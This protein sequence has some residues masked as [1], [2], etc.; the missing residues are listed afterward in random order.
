VI[1]GMR[2]VLARSPGVR[3]VVEFFESMLEN[4]Y[5]VE[6]FVN[7]IHDLGF[8]MC[9]ILP[10]AQLELLPMGEV[11]RGSSYFLL[12]R[13][14]EEDLR[15]NHFVIL[16]EALRY[17]DSFL[18]G[19]RNRLLNDRQLVCSSELLAGSDE[20]V[21][22]FGPYINLAPGKYAFHFQGD[23][24]GALQLKFTKNFGEVL[25]ET[26]IDSFAQPVL[27]ELERTAE[28]FEIVASR[29]NSLRNLQLSEIGVV[30]T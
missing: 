24:Q 17:L 14:H 16:P 22:F 29:T 3:L 28:K 11:P 13:T 23:L 12:T 1:E 8:R 5:G 19:S 15:R 27:L 6:K 10:D 20:S 30:V 9:K 4:T 18:D 2:E 21:L 26:S 7:L 25:L